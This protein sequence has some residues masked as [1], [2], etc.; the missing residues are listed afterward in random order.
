MSSSWVW[1]SRTGTSWTSPPRYA[2]SCDGTEP[3]TLSVGS[4]GD[5]DMGL[6]PGRNLFVITASNRS[7]KDHLDDSIRNPV[8]PE[9][10]KDTLPK[11][12]FDN[13]EKL[14]GDGG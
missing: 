4:G 12:T 1:L 3:S 9:R 11:E 14:S 2:P 6:L 10:V 7:A 8:P 5:S 13:A